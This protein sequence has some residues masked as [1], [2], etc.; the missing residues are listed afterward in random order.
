[1]KEIF[2]LKYFPYFSIFTL[3]WGYH[4]ALKITLP[5]FMISIPFVLGAIY[6]IITS[7]LYF[8]QNKTR[9]FC[10][11]R[12]QSFI[13]ILIVGYSIAT[14]VKL[15]F[16]PSQQDFLRNTLF[17]I[18]AMFGTSCI[19][20]LDNPIAL[21]NM[22]GR[23]LKYYPYIFIFV[24]IPLM[25][26]GSSLA[27]SL[28]FYVAILFLVPRNYKWL[29]YFAIALALFAPGQRMPLLR[30]LCALFF[31]FL[32]KYKIIK[33]KLT[34]NFINLILYT[35]PIAA[36][37][38]AATGFFNIFEANKYIGNFSYGKENLVED[39]RTFLYKEAIAS[40]IDNHY[41]LFGRTFG[42]GYDSK[43]QTYR[44]ELGDTKNILQRNAEV[45]IINIY[46][47]MGLIGVISFAILFF[48]ASHYAVNHSK[49]IYTQYIGILVSIQW[50]FCWIETSMIN[51][52]FTQ[53]IMWMEIAMCL[54][55]FWRNLTNKEFVLI[56]K[57]ILK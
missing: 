52:N 57:N 55:P 9:L 48:L 19:L 39:T 21:K 18:G 10:R 15:F 2:S 12:I 14:I 8:I 3:I 34:Q 17:I 16:V 30:I 6:I 35:F 29:A 33:G 56:M 41:I 53:V 28:V 54:S 42:Y 38:T 7:F 36:F 47:W 4:L 31:Y 44:M 46:T 20:F 37:I 32:F 5:Y 51:I 49:N 22:H 25:N 11:K 23:I 13:Y 45:F 26:I 24:F 43:W 27:D 40:S 1:M 50:V